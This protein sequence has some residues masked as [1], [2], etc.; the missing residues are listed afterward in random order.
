M[1][2]EIMSQLG[3]SYTDEDYETVIENMYED[4]YDEIIEDDKYEMIFDEDCSFEVKELIAQ[5]L[6][7]EN[8]QMMQKDTVDQINES[9]TDA[10][11][12]LEKNNTPEYQCL[13][14]NGFCDPLAVRP[15]YEGY[16]DEQWHIDYMQKFVD[17]AQG[18]GIEDHIAKKMISGL[19]NIL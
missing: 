18:F 9:I 4:I 19:E 5:Y 14:D 3:H 16:I 11:E 6:N 2:N 1:L 17:K 10:L 12:I 13:V 15:P 8:F 7:H